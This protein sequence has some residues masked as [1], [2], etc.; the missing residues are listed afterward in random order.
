MGLQNHPPQ[1]SAQFNLDPPDNS[2]V[3]TLGAPYLQNLD[4]AGTQ[5]ENTLDQL[6]PT[7]NEPV[8]APVAVS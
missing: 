3:V 1:P 5:N 2:G 8:S 6:S 7:I 4:T